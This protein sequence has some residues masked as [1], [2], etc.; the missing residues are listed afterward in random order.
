M[1]GL[2]YFYGILDPHIDIKGVSQLLS[3][4]VKS[5][6]AQEIPKY[7]YYLNG[8]ECLDV[9][10][11]CLKTLPEVLGKMKHL[12]TIILRGCVSLESLPGSLNEALALKKIVVFPP[13]PE[14]LIQIEALQQIFSENNGQECIKRM[15]KEGVGGK[16][17]FPFEQE[18]LMTRLEQNGVEIFF[19]YSA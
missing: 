4:Q 6:E 12:Q 2:S 1:S 15:L 3:L 17:C 7:I 8:L 16:F 11:P 18:E 5:L 9:S 10:A 14:K 19:Q 13:Y